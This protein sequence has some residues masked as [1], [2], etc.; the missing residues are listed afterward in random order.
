MPI[1]VKRCTVLNP[2]TLLP[3]ADDGQ[4]QDCV[5]A[6]TKICFPRPDL[7]EI[8]L[9]N[10]NLQLF[11][12]GSASRNPETGRNQAGF[13]VVTQFETR[14]PQPLLSNFSAQTAELKAL[15]EACKLA[16]S[17]TAKIY[18]DSRYAFGVAHDFVLFFMETQTDS[19]IIWEAH[20]TSQTCL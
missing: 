19:Y 3:T 8:P 16:K 10:L 13:A 15:T 18:T 6:I 2:A 9:T 20:W 7:Q 17:R 14:I 4:P 12:E 5:A 11:V 1:T